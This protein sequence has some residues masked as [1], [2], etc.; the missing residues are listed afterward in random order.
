[1]FLAR[2]GEVNAL[3]KRALRRFT[4]WPW[5]EH[6]TLR[7]RWT[8]HRRLN[9]L[10]VANAQ[11][12]GYV[13]MCSWGVAK[14]PTIGEQGLSYLWLFAMI[15]WRAFFI[16]FSEGKHK[17]RNTNSVMFCNLR[18]NVISFLY[19]KAFWLD[20]GLC[21]ARELGAIVPQID[22]P[23]KLTARQ[24][25]GYFSTLALT[26][27][28][29]SKYFINLFTSQPDVFFRLTYQSRTSKRNNW[30][31]IVRLKLYL[32]LIKKS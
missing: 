22:V 27:R 12:P 7:L 30:K 21:L 9:E 18:S 29:L 23:K 17:S 16:R 6:T 8:G 10:F 2:A 11:V 15:S 13:M 14:E 5:I 3:P 24:T 26:P 28:F 31:E 20:G 4:Q 25:S 1:M 32:D 19:S